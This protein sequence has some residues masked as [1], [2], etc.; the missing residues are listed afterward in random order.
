MTTAITEHYARRDTGDGIFYLAAGPED[1][2]LLV[3]LHGWPEL[4]IS[5]RHQ[6][7]VFAAMGFRAV[8]PDMPGYGRSVIYPRKEDYALENIVANMMFLL[9][10]LGRETAVWI[11]HD[12]GSPPVWSIA[13]HHPDRCQAVASLNIPYRTAELG[14]DHLVSTVDRAVYPEDLYPYGQWDYQVHYQ[15]DFDRATVT[16]DADPENAL[17]LFFTRGDPSM[18]GKPWASATITRQGGWFGDLPSAPEAVLD[19]AV[20]SEEELRHYV[21]ALSRN[22]FFGPNAWYVNHEANRAYTARAVNG[23]YLDMPALF[24]AAEYDHACECIE[25]RFAEE[26]RQHCRNLTAV[27]VAS[28]HWMAQERPR[29]VN[30]ALAH[31]LATEAKVWP[32]L[33]VPRWR[34]LE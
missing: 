33:P 12:W 22:G 14:L 27:S 21:S 4:A 19:E 8:A 9:D 7:P 2:P 10:S 11:G 16:L 17:K 28:G 31:W 20:L 3:F 5:W 26:M 24:L 13:S 25:S 34:P 29:E 32:H 23:G 18:A 6:L 30:A 1:G 15:E